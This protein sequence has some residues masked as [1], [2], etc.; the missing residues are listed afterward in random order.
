VNGEI[1]FLVKHSVF[2][3]KS[4]KRKFLLERKEAL[5]ENGC[6]PAVQI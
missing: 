6:A 4:M 5:F 3:V 1:Q 2:E